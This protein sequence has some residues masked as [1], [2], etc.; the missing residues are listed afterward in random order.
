[1]TKRWMM[2]TGVAVVAAIGIG[3]WMARE[4][5]AQ[6]P[7][8][9]ADVGVVVMR[10]RFDVD[11]LYSGDGPVGASGLIKDVNE[12]R[13]FEEWVLLKAM[14][15]TRSSTLLV[16]RERVVSIETLE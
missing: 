2:I 15:G 14:K 11:I 1:M 9:S 10:G 6:G 16:P 3:A 4:A 12:L 13:I 8:Q 5:S 7:A